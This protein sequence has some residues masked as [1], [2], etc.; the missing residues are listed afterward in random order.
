MT[1][2]IGSSQRWDVDWVSN[3]LVTR[4]VDHVPQSLFCILDTSSFWITVT[5]KDK[6]LLLSC[7]QATHTLLIHLQNMT[8]RSQVER[9]CQKVKQWVWED[10]FAIPRPSQVYTILHCRTASVL[11]HFFKRL[12]LWTQ[13]AT[14]RIKREI[15]YFKS[16][17]DFLIKYFHYTR[18]S[19]ST[20]RSVT[21]K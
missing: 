7:P 13:S 14:V 12:N 9:L 19:P 15:R 11:I 2:W 6:L 16:A 18:R 21:K 8:D 5:Q 3:W 10:C 1:I 20:D 17:N 4:G